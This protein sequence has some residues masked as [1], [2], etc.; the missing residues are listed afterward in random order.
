MVQPDRAVIDMGTNT[1][2]LLIAGYQAGRLQ[3][4]VEEQ[5]PVFIG[6]GG[7][8]DGRLSP[9][10]QER[11]L[12][13]LRSFKAQVT[14]EGIPNER[15]FLSGTS[16]IRS[17]RNGAAFHARI[18]EATGWVPHILEGEEE[19]QY[20]G[21]AVMAELSLGEDPLL[22]MDIGGGSCEFILA[23]AGTCQ[24]ADSFEVGAQRLL[25]R[26]C[27]E[28]PI[29]QEQIDLLHNWLN[30]QLRPLHQLLAEERPLRFAG[31]AGAFTSLFDMAPHLSSEGYQYV[32]KPDFQEVLRKLIESK[33]AERL[34]LE[35]L[36]DF[37]ADMMVPAMLLVESVWR[38]LPAERVWIARS[39]LKEGI[40]LSL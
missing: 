26:F 5:I 1:F 12:E 18:K 36:P 37:R 24:W 2:Q 8:S 4:V 40:A 16:A 31:S 28:D 25:D 15:V 30:K 10:A 29:P 17:A 33:H 9:E 3:P 13:A 38:R 11:A 34:Q 22:I 27:T 19:A 20:I 39:S 32:E 14:R 35:G 21:Q 7:I 23:K 6:R